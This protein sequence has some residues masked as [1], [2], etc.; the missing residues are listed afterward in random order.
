LTLGAPA[1]LVGLFFLVMVGTWGQ[2]NPVQWV[3]TS[4]AGGVDWLETFSAQMEPSVVIEMTPI[5]QPQ[6][7]VVTAVARADGEVPPSPTMAE[8]AAQ[9]QPVA[10]LQAP[11]GEPEA[12]PTPLP[13]VA[14]P[15]IDV[16]PTA[17]PPTA[18]PPT[19][20]P[21]ASPTPQPTATPTP[22]G[23]PT[24]TATRGPIATQTTRPT[25]PVA[26]GATGGLAI[27]PTATP[28]RP[29]PAS[30]P[31][32]AASVAAE[33]PLPT[34]TPIPA[35]A[36][37]TA[38]ATPAPPRTYRV[39]A[40]DTLVGIAARLG[41]TVEA[42]MRANNIASSDVY[43]IQPG[44]E[45]VI[46]GSGTDIPTATP[47]PP[48]ATP[49]ARPP[50]T[51]APTATQVAYRLDP[52]LLRSPEDGTPV[53][54]GAQDSLVWIGVP[55]IQPTDRYLLHLG[56][57]SGYTADG[58]EVVTW[59]LEQP[60]PF[61]LT[62]WEMDEALCGLAPQQYGRQWRWWVEV[63]AEEDGRYRPVSP[64]SEVWGFSWQ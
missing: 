15:T 17:A 8:V 23:T 30:A 22:T 54:C 39:Q 63:V 29:A 55:F 49:T 61:N 51:P 45:L 46:P 57:V 28:T 21:T 10:A 59:V 40:G 62:S 25:T 7:T 18:E 4:L 5:V 19:A 47:Q 16:S 3:Q 44:Q 60:R 34:P 1:L 26:E 35:T 53:S 24:S 20:V 12:T 56:F 9:D 37:P 27:L 41:V 36:T 6:E 42:L 52:P 50:A 13:A 2:G 31:V 43:R 11:A 14:E 48:T 32:Q 64:P 38:T 58:Q 33:A